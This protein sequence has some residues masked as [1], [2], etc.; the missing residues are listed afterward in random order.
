MA[1]A[2]RTAGTH[3]YVAGIFPD[4]A[5]FVAAC[6]AA[7]TAGHSDLQAWTPWPVHGLEDILGLERSRLGRAV[8]AAIL[9]GFVVCFVGIHHISVLGWPVVYG[10]KPFD[11]WQ[12]WVVPVLETGLLAGA[13]VNLLACFHTCRLLP[14]PFTALPDGRL[15]D[16][17]F[18][19]ALPAGADPLAV[20]AWF[21]AQGAESTLDLDGATTLAGPRFADLPGQ[22]APRA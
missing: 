2:V 8:L 18:A 3:P 7:R 21:A 6:R 19:L 15:S 17:R 1:D 13:V 4:E 14:D 5:S 9:L 10:G 12:L 22:E 20:R 11:T 16:D